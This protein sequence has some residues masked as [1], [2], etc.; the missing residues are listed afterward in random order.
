MP[1]P[2]DQ[3]FL[4]IPL[5]ALQTQQPGLLALHKLPHG[6]G[7]GAVDFGL[8]EYGEADAVIFH[9]KGLRGLVGGFFLIHELR[10]GE[11]EEFDVRGVFGFEVLQDVSEEDPGD[12][13]EG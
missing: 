7:V 13:L 4:K 12:N 2:A 11:P 8:R 1:I 6:L 5:D 10:A 3:K 9:A